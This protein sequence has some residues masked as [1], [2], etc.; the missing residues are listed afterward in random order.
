MQRSLSFLKH[1]ENVKEAIKFELILFDQFYKK[2][3][4]QKQSSKDAPVKYMQTKNKNTRNRVH[5]QLKQ[6]ADSLLSHQE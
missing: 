1:V 5:S 6:Q 2:Y 4:L 3:T